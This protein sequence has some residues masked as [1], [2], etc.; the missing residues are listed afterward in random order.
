LLWLRCRR[1]PLAVSCLPPTW[2]L[3]Y[4]TH[5]FRQSRNRCSSTPPLAKRYSSEWLPGDIARIDPA[6]GR[7]VDSK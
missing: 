7:R 6:C 3:R 1:I 2:S 4:I 5:V